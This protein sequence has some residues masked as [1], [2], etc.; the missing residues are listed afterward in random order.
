MKVLIIIPSLLPGG[1]QRVASL[2][3]AGLSKNH[4]IYFALA[5][6]KIVYPYSGE[7]IDL[8]IKNLDSRGLASRFFCTA[9]F[10]LKLKRLKKT[11][12]P[13]IALSFLDISNIPN[14]L[15]G[16]KTILSVREFKMASGDNSAQR[17]VAVRLMKLLYNRSSKVVVNSRAMG[18]SME[19]HYGIKKERIK[20]IYNPLDIEGIAGSC[21]ARLDDELA[22]VFAHPVV[23]TAGRLTQA[24]GHWHLIRSFA[25]IKKSVPDAKLVILGDGELRGYLQEL[26]V[27]LGIRDDVL[28][29]GFRK[30]PFKFISRA[31]VF[32]F[33]SLWEGFPNA[34]L[35]AMACGVPV[36]STDCPS[37]PR[38]ILSPDT[39]FHIKTDSPEYAKYGILM[40]V[41][42]GE[43]KDASAPLVK[44]E[45]I[46]ADAM[47]EM[48]KNSALR[49]DYGAKA[50]VRASDFNMACIIPQWEKLILV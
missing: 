49:A 18:I 35:E 42:D 1:A 9:A 48:L 38:E 7:L 23:L 40:P 10:A 36:I 12:V 24:K 15:S 31:T 45:K 19:N 16:S 28:F 21:G 8:R 13:D 41:F 32:A 44:E 5:E 26:S 29:A 25:E 4:E 22:G 34:L 46:W 33:T 43:I 27:G 39:D 30:N 2:I 20:V 37:G 14:V 3:S 47:V 50:K 17:R 11:V 6:K